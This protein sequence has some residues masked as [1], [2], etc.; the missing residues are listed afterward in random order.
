MPFEGNRSLDQG[1]Q[2]V[3]PHEPRLNLE[4]DPAKLILTM[5]VPGVDPNA[6]MLIP[7]CSS[8]MLRCATVNAV[9]VQEGK[10]PS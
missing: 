10:T 1:L 7:D 3:G 8:A 9:A 2:F 6:R 4:P 5:A